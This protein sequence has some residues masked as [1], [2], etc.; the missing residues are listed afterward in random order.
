[1]LLQ[2]LVSGLDEVTASC[3]WLW[4]PVILF[5]WLPFTLLPKREDL[6]TLGWVDTSS[7]LF[8]TLASFSYFYQTRDGLKVLN[9]Q[10][11]C[12]GTT[13]IQQ[14]K[15]FFVSDEVFMGCSH[16]IW[17][18]WVDS[19]TAVGSSS[20]QVCYAYYTFI[21]W[22]YSQQNIVLHIIKSTFKSVL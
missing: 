9:P 5:I 13:A 4:L 2:G 21:Y 17:Q 6:Q 1:M 14:L 16:F 22:L 15:P 3:S 18:L 10:Y 12:I 19:L 7:L 20:H 11:W 8:C